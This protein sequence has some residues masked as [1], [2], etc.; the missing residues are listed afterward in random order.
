MAAQ[1]LTQEVIEVVAGAESST[2][3]T[4]LPVEVVAGADSHLRLTQLIIEVVYANVA[5]SGARMY[6][7]VI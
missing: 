3:L 2:R 5:A 6:V 1:R 7:S 4:Q